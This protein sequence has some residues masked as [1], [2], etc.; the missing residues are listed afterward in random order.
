[1]STT[2]VFI[3]LLAGREIALALLNKRAGKS[4]GI[5]S[6]LGIDL[7]KVF[8]GLTISVTVILFIHFLR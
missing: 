2:W 4:K 6:L 8:A 1:M 3:G 7:I 5:I